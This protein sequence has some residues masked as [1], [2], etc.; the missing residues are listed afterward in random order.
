MSDAVG[1]DEFVASTLECII[2]GTVKAQENS[3][4]TGA[5]INPQPWGN[6]GD[7]A[8]TAQY[9]NT[10]IKEVE[11]NVAIT[12]LEG[13]KTSGGIG[14]ML[15]AFALGSQGKSSAETGSVSRIRFV[16]PIAL[17]RAPG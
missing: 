3:K 2:N 6:S 16:V 8:L 14:V 17:T 4:E 13:S 9:V 12:K 1:L 7:K 15:G 10:L 5:K 11:F